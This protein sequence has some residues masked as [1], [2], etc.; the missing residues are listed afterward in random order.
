MHQSALPQ[1]I[2]GAEGTFPSKPNRRREDWSISYVGT[3]GRLG[4]CQ[5]ENHCYS[6]GRGLGSQ[7]S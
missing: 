4:H 5:H 6:R 1:W 2:I 3:F 7:R